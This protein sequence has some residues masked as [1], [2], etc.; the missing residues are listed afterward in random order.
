MYV[1]K[2]G[3]GMNSDCPGCRC[4]SGNAFSPEPF[5]EETGDKQPESYVGSSEDTVLLPKT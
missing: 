1:E 3:R 5:V 2:I 4:I